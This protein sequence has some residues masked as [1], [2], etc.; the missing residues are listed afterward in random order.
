ML[1]SGQ[2]AWTQ[3]WDTGLTRQE[4]KTQQIL[5]KYNTETQPHNANMYLHEYSYIIKIKTL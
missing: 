1:Q 3:R 2:E 4:N 5:K